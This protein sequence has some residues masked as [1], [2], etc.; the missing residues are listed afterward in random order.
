M[1]SAGFGSKFLDNL[2]LVVPLIRNVGADGGN[3]TEY[4]FIYTINFYLKKNDEFSIFQDVFMYLQIPQ[5]CILENIRSYSIQSQFKMEL[6][7]L[8]VFPLRKSVSS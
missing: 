1:Q 2:F 3:N 4:F 8:S 6:Y 7:F 5:L